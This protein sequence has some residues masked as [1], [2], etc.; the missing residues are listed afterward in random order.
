MILFSKIL[1]HKLWY[2]FACYKLTVA[3]FIAIYSFF[4]YFERGGFHK[5]EMAQE[6]HRRGKVPYS[7]RG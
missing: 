1:V 7:A 4:T 6:V 5:Q 2:F 3:V